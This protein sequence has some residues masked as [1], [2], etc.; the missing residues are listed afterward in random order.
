M[1]TPKLV[2]TI[3]AQTATEDIFFGLN[4]SKN[5]SSTDGSALTYIAAGLPD[6]LTIN[7]T[8]GVINGIPT[9]DAV[10]VRTITVTA[11]D[12]NG[13][14]V[15]GSFSLTVLN[16]ND[17]P[18]VSS[19]IAD[20]TATEDAPFSVNISSNFADIDV[21]DTLTYKA[22]GLPTGFTINSTTGV[23]IGTPT[24]ALVGNH[25]ITVTATDSKGATVSAAFK[26]TVLNTNDAPT[27]AAPIA[28]RT[29][30]EDNFFSMG[31]S[32]AFADIDV[33]DRLT[34]SATGLP[35][36][37]TINDKTGVISGF[38]T[39]AAVG[40]SKVTVTAT[41]TGGLSAST[42]LHITVTNTN[43]APIVV[44]P[45]AAATAK[46]DSP[47]SV[48]VS[49]YF[50]D[51]DKGDTLK[52]SA[53]GLPDG[54]AIA[55]ATG[56]ISGSPTNA[57]VGTR[58]VTV[59][60]NDGN[61]GTVSTNFQIT[62]L[63]TND[64]PTVFTPIPD[65]TTAEDAFFS[66]NVSNHFLDIDLGDT[67]SFYA[68]GLPDGLSLDSKTGVISG[69]PT[70]AA[71]GANTVVITATDGN[72]GTANDAFTLTVTNTNDTPVV[73]YP[74]EAATAKEDSA[75]NLDISYH[76]SDPDVGDVLTY[77]ALSLPSGL[78]INSTTGVISGTPTNDGVGTSKVTVIASDGKGGTVQ[79]AFD[80]TVLNTND[81][82]TVVG[83]IADSEATEGTLYTLDVSKS[84]TDIDRGDT[85]A[86]FATNLPDGLTLN[87]ETGLLSGIPTNA[88]VGQH[89]VTI[90]ATDNNGGQAETNFDLVVNNTNSAPIVS[91]PLDNATAT[92][93]F[94]F[95]LDVS[96][97]FAD[98]D[99]G[100]VLTYSAKLPDGLSIDATTGVIS[101][102]PTN[103]AVGA[104]LVMVTANDGKGGTVDA[105]FTL[106]VANT[107][108]DPVIVAPAVAQSTVVNVPFTFNVSTAFSDPDIGDT[109]TYYVTDLP[110]GLAL[111][112][113]SGVISGTPS[114]LG[115]Q[116]VTVTAND[117]N[118]GIVNESFD[119]T[120]VANTAPTV[121]I[122][123]A[124]QTLTANQGFS[125]SISANA[126]QD[127][128]PS[129]RL[130]LSATLEDG[131]ALPSW[132]SFDP[133]TGTVSGTPTTANVGTLNLRVTATDRSGASTSDGLTLTVKPSS[134]TVP[135]PT[136]APS[137]I[138]S[139]NG[140]TT[141][142]PPVI[143]AP[144]RVTS[145]QIMNGTGRGD[146][147]TGTQGDDVLN[148]GAGND[149]LI[150]NDG[151]DVLVGGTGNDF[152]DGGAGSDRLSGGPGNDTLIGG[153][154]S[155]VFV[156]E[157]GK[158]RDLIR[159]FQDQQDKLELGR[160]MSF[161]DLKLTR[162][163]RNTI[164]SIGQDQLAILVGVKV[165]QITAADFTTGSLG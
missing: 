71:V 145:G 72:G 95:A 107:N 155:D 9:N 5:F 7:S 92:E 141:P 137:I 4:I 138:P 112:G 96:N 160:G 100:D 158:G 119:L 52:Y 90:I 11:Q 29:A 42:S 118:G 16:T 61:R 133:I 116:T 57:A 55:A 59:T 18:M 131:N 62:I 14:T 140:P 12:G 22:T 28:D 1:T 125:F 65:R 88:G 99:E 54:L 105:S 123:L 13:G 8:T 122:P 50:A 154:G 139:G 162:S 33:G 73:T 109:L 128:D 104:N 163:G 56:I 58:T 44:A 85:L 83:A 165:N 53:T 126:F 76:F 60:A 80:L 102:I 30:V 132:L 156:L 111:D 121:V 93:D 63:N 143:N 37:L 82:P 124:A 25:N 150:G 89:T 135:L 70:N 47:F 113:K 136:P 147:F 51:I 87:A 2:T 81:D 36:G 38:A 43:D 146:R 159:D 68:Q 40:T 45:I 35:E 153:A 10:G 15:S 151:N 98:P 79:G 97:A 142:I 69:F 74:L 17:A 106:T 117:G 27:V 144:N 164:V 84:F 152:L 86:F 91:L 23:I 78:S 41:D 26:L 67:L 19:P 157:R 49:G 127:S 149:R 34:Y 134:I 148:G 114:Q 6:G 20:Q 64:A 108:D 3:G 24:N 161:S 103:A 46:E 75:F 130:T 32:S 120:V 129:D 48:D 110:E 101:G 39:N 77:A 21:G 94:P 31:V 66:M 115:T